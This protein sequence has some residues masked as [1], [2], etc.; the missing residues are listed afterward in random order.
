MAL[1]RLA[2]RGAM[3]RIGRDL[4]RGGAGCFV[5]H[6]I[7]AKVCFSGYL[8]IVTPRLWA[9]KPLRKTRLAGKPEKQV[10]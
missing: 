5:P 1:N 8:D 4:Q 10:K 2:N 7:L 9:V 6:W 3:R